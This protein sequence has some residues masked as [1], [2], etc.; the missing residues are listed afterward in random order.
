MKQEKILALYAIKNLYLK[1]DIFN[2]RHLKRIRIATDV[3]MIAVPKYKVSNP[4]IDDEP[5]NFLCFLYR[6]E[7]RIL[8]DLIYAYKEYRDFEPS[9]QKDL[10]SQLYFKA[11]LDMTLLTYNDMSKL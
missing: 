9:I 6:G 8:S 11:I 5:S 4:T 7:E 10:I 2:M 3:Q 1:E